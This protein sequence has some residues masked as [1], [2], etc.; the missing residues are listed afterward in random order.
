MGSVLMQNL[1]ILDQVRKKSLKKDLL[2]VL[3]TCYWNGRG[4]RCS[5]KE[6]IGSELARWEEV[7]VCTIDCFL[8]FIKQS[9][10]LNELP[11]MLL[12]IKISFQHI[13]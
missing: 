10:V 13:L 7:K 6:I 11:Q 8:F 2:R 12:N 1:S 4:R 3:T 9:F 5:L